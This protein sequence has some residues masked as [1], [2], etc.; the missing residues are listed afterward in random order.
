VRA[1]SWRASAHPRTT[2]GTPATAYE[3]PRL[4]RRPFPLQ[5]GL[6][7]TQGAVTPF[8]GRSAFPQRPAPWVHAA[9]G[10]R[11]RE[12]VSGECP[13]Q[14]LC[15]KLQ[16]SWHNMSYD[17]SCSTLYI[18]SM[19]QSEKSEYSSCILLF[20][21]ILHHASFFSQCEFEI[22]LIFALAQ[23]S[24]QPTVACILCVNLLSIAPQHFQY[25]QNNRL[26]FPLVWCCAC[27]RRVGKSS[28]YP[29]GTL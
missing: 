27:N 21:C 6:P 28:M 20:S 23:I 2:F 9:Y 5:E 19:S 11:Q 1:S 25:N 15:R 14:V 24:A 22:R 18:T 10:E 12:S 3:L 13:T 16:S 7:D 17:L 4:L 8:N 29:R 26:H